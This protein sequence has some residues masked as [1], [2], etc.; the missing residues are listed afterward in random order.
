MSLSSLNLILSSCWRTI[1][2]QTIRSWRY[3]FALGAPFSKRCMVGGWCSMFGPSRLILLPPS[4]KLTAGFCFLVLVD[5]RRRRGRSS[6]HLEKEELRRRLRESESQKNACFQQEQQKQNDHHH[7][8]LDA[9]FDGTNVVG[10]W[11][12]GCRLPAMLLCSTTFLCFQWWSKL[13]QWT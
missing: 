12:C 11:H 2:V 10:T 4:F 1:H 6:E 13:F 8:F 7:G 9:R 5:R 3:A